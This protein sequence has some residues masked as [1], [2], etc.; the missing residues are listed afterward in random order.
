MNLQQEIATLV[1][2]A[3]VGLVA[4][5]HQPLQL[6]RGSETDRQTDRQRKSIAKNTSTFHKTTGYDKSKD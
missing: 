3:I 2:G 6:D 4:E 5:T 1:T